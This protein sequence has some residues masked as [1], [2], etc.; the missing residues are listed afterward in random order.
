MHSNH[1]LP[2][3]TYRLHISLLFDFRVICQELYNHFIN[4]YKIFNRGYTT[5]IFKPENE[6]HACNVFCS[7]YISGHS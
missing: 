2:N 6:R 4:L 1:Y 5:I 3:K 7:K